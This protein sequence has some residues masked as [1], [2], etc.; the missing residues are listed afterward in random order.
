M[1]EGCWRE[2]KENG[3]KSKWWR[4]VDSRLIGWLEVDG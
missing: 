3:A 1:E 2:N 4:K